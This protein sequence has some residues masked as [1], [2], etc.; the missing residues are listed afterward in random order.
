VN[1]VLKHLGFPP[2]SV[3]SGEAPM[4]RQSDSISAEWAEAYRR[5]IAVRPHNTPH[6][7][8]HSE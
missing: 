3:E 8:S 4:R 7:L 1:A 5:G 2:I 6:P